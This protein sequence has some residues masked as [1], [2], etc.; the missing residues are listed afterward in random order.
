[1]CHV[2]PCQCSKVGRSLRPGQ[3]LTGQQATLSS[4][5]LF[6]SPAACQPLLTSPSSYG[7][8]QDTCVKH[9]EVLCDS[10]DHTLLSQSGHWTGTGQEAGDE[11]TRS[12]CLQLSDFLSTFCSLEHCLPLQP[13]NAVCSAPNTCQPSFATGPTTTCPVPA[14]QRPHPGGRAAP[15]LL[16]DRFSY[17]GPSSNCLLKFHPLPFVPSVL[18]VVTVS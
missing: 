16:R 12:R 6:P 1:M 14:F 15:P 10:A 18:Q 5:A 11:G 2:N 9:S 8:A 7:T 13:L 4:P 3:S 17:E